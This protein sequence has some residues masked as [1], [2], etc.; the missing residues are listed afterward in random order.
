[1]VDPALD[2]ITLMREIEDLKVQ[3]SDYATQETN[4][5]FALQANSKSFH[6]HFQKVETFEHFLSKYLLK[7]LNKSVRYGKKSTTTLKNPKIT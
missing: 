1:M 5:T 3:L 6:R 2:Q 4:L 7:Y